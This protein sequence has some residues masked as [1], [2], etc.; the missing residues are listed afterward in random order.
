[1]KTFNAVYKYGHLYDRDTNKRLLLKD[2][3]KLVVVIDSEE[4]DLYRVDPKNNPDDEGNQPRSAEKILEQ[5][6]DEHYNRVEKV[7]NRGEYLYFTIKAGE[8][9]EQK[10]R[11]FNCCFR[12]QL[13]EEL[14]MVWKTASV[15]ELGEFF[16]KDNQSCSCVVDQLEYGE[17]DGRYFERVYGSSLSDVRTLTYEMYFSR[18]GRSG[19]NIYKVLLSQ[20]NERGEPFMGIRERLNWDRRNSK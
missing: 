18:F 5:I 10:R 2:D 11:S 9:D 13:L 7:A 1:M 3:I 19:V 8:R 16:S 15:N 17:I 6:K 12:V 4:T 14:Y 20:P